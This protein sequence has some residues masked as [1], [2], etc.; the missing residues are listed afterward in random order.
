MSLRGFAEAM[1]L[2]VEASVR[3]EVT[4]FLL[5]RKPILFVLGVDLIVGGVCIWPFCLL[6]IFVGSLFL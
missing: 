1:T 6:C 2:A 3:T 4:L 5:K